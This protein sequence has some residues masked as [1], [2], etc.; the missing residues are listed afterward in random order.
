MKVLF[1]IGR[2]AHVHLFRV[3]MAHL[4]MTN[5]LFTVIKRGKEMIIGR[6]SVRELLLCFCFS[7]HA[8]HI[9][10]NERLPK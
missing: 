4:T 5:I 2:P 3:L 10:D 1:D 7:V 6:W 9:Q 8:M